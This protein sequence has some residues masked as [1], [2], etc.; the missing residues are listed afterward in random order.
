MRL[1]L[2]I[3]IIGLLGFGYSLKDTPHKHIW[4]NVVADTVHLKALTMWEQ[5]Y[6][7]SPLK[8]YEEGEDIACIECHE[9][10]KVI[11]HRAFVNDRNLIPSHKFDTIFIHG[12]MNGVIK[13]NQ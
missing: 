13:F 6:V 11:Y 8:E 5:G 9:Q 4:V 7:M 1:L 2:I 3:S 10:K 12:N